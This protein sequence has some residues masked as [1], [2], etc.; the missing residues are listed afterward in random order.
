MRLRMVTPRS[1]TRTTPPRAHRLAKQNHLARRPGRCIESGYGSVIPPRIRP[2]FDRPA[3]VRLTQRIGHFQSE[4][5][6][7]LKVWGE[8][9]PDGSCLMVSM[10]KQHGRLWASMRF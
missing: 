10:Q 6:Y 2:D 3:G 4:T 5:V 7:H 8:L 1:V 9:C